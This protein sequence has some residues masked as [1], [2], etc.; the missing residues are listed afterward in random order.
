MLTGENMRN[1]LTVAKYDFA[2]QEAKAV[3]AGY[4]FGE[5]TESLDPPSPAYGEPLE[6]WRRARFGDRSYD[7]QRG[8]A[9]GSTFDGTSAG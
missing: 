2:L 5:V 3:V 8:R 6:P 7:C 9:R 1:G 4:C